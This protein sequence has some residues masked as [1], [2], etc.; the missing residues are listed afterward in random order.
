MNIARLFKFFIFSYLI[1]WFIWLP[2]YAP[3]FGINF[4]P[5]MPYHHALGGLGPLMASFILAYQSGKTEGLKQHM[6][7]MFNIK[8]KILCILVA[9]LGP[10][11]IITLALVYNAMFNYVALS[12]NGIG[13]SSEFPGMNT[14]TFFIY[15]LI[16][17]GFGEEAGWR[18]IALPELQKRF[19]P[20][21]ANAILTF[22]WAAWHIPL[23]FYRPGYTQM[24]MGGIVGWLASLFTGSILLTWM[25]N[26]SKSI[27]VCA[28]FHSTIDIVFTSQVSDK[29]IVSIAGAIITLWGLLTLAFFYKDF[30][31]RR[32]P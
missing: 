32:S 2:L 14:V 31:V 30:F 16:F 27:L 17:F 15:N 28:I 12:F 21:L 29:N 10:F 6:H 25:Y 13:T 11:L 19:N 26:R 23:F 20:F 18:G 9:A 4:L 7:S 22:G 3:A 24:D 5:V 8:G 1:S